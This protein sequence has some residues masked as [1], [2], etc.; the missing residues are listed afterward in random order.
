MNLSDILK[1]KG[2]KLNGKLANRID[3]R[4]L[5]SFM[6]SEFLDE[7]KK[8]QK[9]LTQDL[10]AY[11]TIKFLP[12]LLSDIPIFNY[13]CPADAHGDYFIGNISAREKTNPFYLRES[14][15]IKHLLFAGASGSGK[16]NVSFLLIKQFLEKNKPFLVIDWKRNYRDMI[17]FP[18]AKD[19]D[20]LIFTVGRETCPFLFNPLIPPEGTSPHVWLAKLIEI[21][22]HAYFLGEG[23]IYLLS[24][25]INTV[26]ND[27]G[28]YEGSGYWPTFRNVLHFLE[29][30][31][32]KGRE[33][34]WLASAVRA[35]TTLC[36]GEMDRVLNRGNYPIGEILKRNVILEVDA[37]T[38]SAKVFLTES[39]L[40]WIHHYRMAEGKRETCKHVCII[41]EAHHILS[42]KLQWMSGTETITDIL[43]RE[44]REFGESLIIIDQDPSLLSIPALGNTY[45]TICLNL[46]ERNDVNVMAS[47]LNLNHDEKEFLTKLEVGQG[48]VKLQGRWPDPF[49]INI[50]KVPVTKGSVTDE[51]LKVKMAKFYKELGRSRL[52]TALSESSRQ[53]PTWIKEAK[54]EKTRNKPRDKTKQEL[55]TRNYGTLELIENLTDKEKGFLEDILRNPVSKASERYTRIGMNWYQGTKAQQSLIEKDMIRVVK[56]QSFSKAG[57]WGKTFELT[58]RARLALVKLGYQLPDEET[59]RRGSLQHKHLVKLIE[60]KLR[61]EGHSVEEE[62]PLGEGKTTDLVVDRKIAIEIERNCR[63]TIDNVKKNLAKVLSVLIVS[64]TDQ[65]KNEIADLL[66]QSGMQ[67]KA[68]VVCVDEL[69]KSTPA[70][71]N[72]LFSSPSSGASNLFSS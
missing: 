16:T 36:F 65:M 22:C 56:L 1:E 42:R 8:E 18:E 44:I 49:L 55:K 5:T 37:L 60:D 9:T 38:D 4:L 59:K 48:I 57:Y 63:N 27:F 33:T 72:H 68:V 20:I 41:E 32:C 61:K 30:Y 58:E 6:L 11:L 51:M 10:N 35:A 31:E 43:L 69:L 34:Q 39:L 12:E 50:P 62:F 67:D 3:K 24:K 70:E 64:E 13:P 29:N 15:M 47:I 52:E 54:I 2:R 17:T 53:D 45:T 25:A 23:V 19:K 14:E 26:Y 40:L 46:K 66:E 71:F 28:V 7:D 21:I